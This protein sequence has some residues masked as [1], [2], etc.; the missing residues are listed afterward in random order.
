MSDEKKLKTA[1]EIYI[2]DMIT[3]LKTGETTVDYIK[4]LA[5]QLRD[6]E[7]IMMGP[8]DSDLCAAALDRLAAS[9]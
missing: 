2:T 5:D 6:S 8:T 3:S 1:E 9:L 4:G 7:G